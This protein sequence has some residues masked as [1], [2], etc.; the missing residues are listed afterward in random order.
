M[1]QRTGNEEHAFL[2]PKG[3][4]VRHPLDDEVAG[5]V[6][7]RQRTGVRTR[8]W[9]IQIARRATAQGLVRPLVVVL[10]AE[11]GVH[12]PVR[13]GH[14]QSRAE[15]LE[16]D[17]SGALNHVCAV[18]EANVVSAV[19]TRASYIAL[20][21]GTIALGLGV[22]W[23]GGALGS[24]LRDVLGD[25]LWAAMVMWWVGAAAPGAPLRTRTATALAL[26]FGVEISQ[27]YHATA[28]D[29]LRS[30]TAGQLILGSGFDPRDLMAYTLGVLVAA[31]FE[32]AVV[33]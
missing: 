6:D 8:G 11:P 30:T 23:R 24:T 12:E 19:R 7:R 21:L 20:A 3:P 18:S 27:L 13:D 32:R 33:P 14:P 29:A 2:E 28:L 26:C 25:A 31:F 16:Q 15:G 5:I 1:N 10:V 22:H 9:P 4:R 17:A